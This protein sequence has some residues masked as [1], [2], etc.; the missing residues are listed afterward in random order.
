MS[1]KGFT[2][3][4]DRCQ[5]LVCCFNHLWNFKAP[6]LTHFPLFMSLLWALKSPRAPE[7]STEEWASSFSQWALK[8]IPPLETER[9][10]AGKLNFSH[11]P[12]SKMIYS[13]KPSRGD[14][15]TGCS[16]ISQ[17]IYSYK[18]KHL[19]LSH[20]GFR[21]P[22]FQPLSETAVPLRL[23]TPRIPLPSDW[24]AFRKPVIGGALGSLPL[25]QVQNQLE[26]LCVMTS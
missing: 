26:D 2:N 12:T 9:N 10:S 24:L 11:C 18:K 25:Q 19:Y 5:V 14:E 6:K 13:S 22:F 17:Q 15:N 4:A 20:C 16:V 8:G 21:K 1:L 23:L 3:T 7:L